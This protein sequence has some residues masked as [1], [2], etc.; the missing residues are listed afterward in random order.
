MRIHLV[1]LL[2]F[3]MFAELVMAQD[4]H[5]S[6]FYANRQNLNP[7]MAGNYNGRYQVGLNY[8]SQWAQ[9]GNEP[10]TTSMLS[11]D[12][13]VAFFSDEIALGGIVVRDEFQGFNTVTGKYLVT[14]AYIKK[15]NF[16]EL[17]AGVQF[18]LTTRGT[19][20]SRQTFPNQWVRSAGIFDQNVDNQ[21]RRLQ[22]NQNFIDVN[23]GL[24]WS[25][26][27]AK[28]KSTAG[29]SFFHINNPN[30]TYFNDA[31]EG[32][33][34]RPLI[35]GELEFGLNHGYRLIPRVMHMWTTR[36]ENTLLGANLHKELQNLPIEELYAGLLY[37][38]GFGRNGDA[39]IPIIGL[40][41]K[42]VDVG[43]SYDVNVSELSAGSNQK[44]TLEFSLLYT[45]PSF[46]PRKLSIPCDRF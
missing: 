45:P 13:K 26:T 16:H 38:D 42:T 3:L 44:G 28:F 11:Y 31:V 15:I 1:F 29:I 40:R 2:L 5:L 33:R 4:V 24:A 23:V 41:Y 32:L 7:A 6:Q 34:M 20:L 37:R 46:S 25:K 30:D 36:S 21:E 9:I 8:R 18:G 27:F 22:E 43:L 17:R 39:L 14:A 19:D 35:H 12:Q 10:I